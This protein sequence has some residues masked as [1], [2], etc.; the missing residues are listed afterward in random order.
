MRAAIALALLL[1]TTACGTEE[2]CQSVEDERE[3]VRALFASGQPKLGADKWQECVLPFGASSTEIASM[4]DTYTQLGM[5]DEALPLYETAGKNTPQDT[6]VHLRVAEIYEERGETALAAAAYERVVSNSKPLIT[7]LGPNNESRFWSG[8]AARSSAILALARL[9][10]DRRD[11]SAIRWF[12]MEI[13]ENVLSQEA[14][15]GKLEALGEGLGEESPTE[16]VQWALH[17][18]EAGR[19]HQEPRAV[20]LLRGLIPT[21]GGADALC[22]DVRRRTKDA[23]AAGSLARALIDACAQAELANV[24]GCSCL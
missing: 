8:D 18:A 9:A 19:F 17:N 13:E 4:A 12:D 21:A 11:A 14:F 15:L 20:A 5:P 1:A 7:K 16:V 23:G 3:E 10:L 2:Q 22:A 24:P 6:Y